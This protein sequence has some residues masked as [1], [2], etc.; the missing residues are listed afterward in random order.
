MDFRY[1]KNACSVV[2]NDTLTMNKLLIAII[3]IVI[4]ACSQPQQK[5]DTNTLD[6]GNFTIDAPKSWKPIKEKGV[7]SYVGRIVIDENDTLSFDL[8]CYSNKL[9]ESVSLALDSSMI[10]SVDTDVIDMRTLLFVNNGARVNLDKLTKNEVLWD[11]I[12]GRKAKVVYP[13]KSGRGTTGIYID[14]L[15]VRGFDVDKFNLYG[16]DLKPENEKKV[17]QALKTIKF[18]KNY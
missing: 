7:D 3:V 5:D 1:C 16:E 15:W 9:Y 2:G 12:D 4:I 17:L 14:S 10:D 13:K 8:G 11:T 18:K 6:F